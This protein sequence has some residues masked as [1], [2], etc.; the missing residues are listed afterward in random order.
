MTRAYVAQGR[1][2]INW[3]QWKN[4]LPDVSTCAFVHPLV[5]PYMCSFAIVMSLFLYVEVP[6][7]MGPSIICPKTVKFLSTFI[8]NNTHISVNVY[9]YEYLL[10]LCIC[11]LQCAK[12]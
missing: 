6:T 8:P 7:H 4:S 1:Q 3:V 12:Y 10:C 11:S 2:A 9:N 5:V